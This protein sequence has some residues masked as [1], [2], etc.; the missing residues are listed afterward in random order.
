MTITWRSKARISS[1]KVFLLLFY[2]RINKTICKLGCH[3]AGLETLFTIP[4]QAEAG[5]GRRKFHSGRVWVR[6]NSNPTRPVVIPNRCW[7][8]KMGSP[9]H[10]ASDRKLMAAKVQ[11]ICPILHVLH[12]CSIYIVSVIIG[13][14]LFLFTLFC[15]ISALI[16]WWSCTR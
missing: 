10:K 14:T 5:L 8:R 16:R 15:F 3:A 13:L 9:H 4:S 7:N 1:A 6:L 2:K 11:Y 12:F